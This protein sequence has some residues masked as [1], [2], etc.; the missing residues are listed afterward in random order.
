M[1]SPLIS[2]IIL[3]YN[4]S[5]FLPDC[6]ANALAQDWPNKEVIVVDDCSTDHSREIIGEY[7]S[8]V[9]PVLQPQNRGH[10]AGMNAGFLHSKGDIIIFCDADDYLY[11]KALRRIVENQSPSAAQYQYR[12]DLL[13]SEGRVVDTYPPKE[14][15]W[16]DGDVTNAL[17]TRGR[18]STTVTSGLAF[19]RSAL[20]RI[21]PMDEE[22][23]RQGGDGYLVTVAPFY[24]LVITIDEILGAYRQH[25]A[26]HSQFGAALSK[27]VRWRITHDAL[28]YQALASHAQR[29]G[30]NPIP[31]VWQNDPLHLEGRMAS[32]LLNPDEHPYV[33]DT[34]KA[35]AKCAL[36][37]CHS[38]PMSRK[39][40]EFMT[41]WWK[42]VGWGP[43]PLARSAL[44]W[45][46]NPASRPVVMKRLAKF[47]RGATG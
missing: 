7:G 18:Y 20:E 23:F 9:I 39:R 36:A 14:F 15:K 26:N 47:M 27:C 4:Y 28:R 30:K 32:L 31:D 16:E 35:I 1:E 12:L 37:A 3:N 41:L 21:M 11:P 42:V 25:G 22:A 8:Q 29:H 46:L 33:R 10:G 40:R 24:G 19:S 6:I 17:L 13:D 5:R 43:L 38:L 45:K 34:R 44:Q 2:V